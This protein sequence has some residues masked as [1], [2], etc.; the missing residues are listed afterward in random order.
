MGLVFMFLGLFFILIGIII[1]GIVLL[2]VGLASKEKKKGC[3]IAG[4]IL[5]GCAFVFGIILFIVFIISSAVLFS[6][7]LAN[8]L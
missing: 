1:A 6:V 5:L 7:S 2:V 3:I 8:Q 4:G